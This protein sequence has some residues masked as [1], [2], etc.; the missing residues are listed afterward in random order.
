MISC[1]SC[2][3]TLGGQAS[4]LWHNRLDLVLDHRYARRTSD[5]DDRGQVINRQLGFL[6][7]LCDGRAKGR[8][9]V[10]ASSLE[11]GARNL[12]LEIDVGEEVLNLHSQAPCQPS[13]QTKKKKAQALSPSHSAERKKDI[14]EKESQSWH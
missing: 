1:F 8:G 3:P 7:S 10:L 14:R 6:Q 12:A 5:Q 2:R 9:Q 11:F 4:A 13:V